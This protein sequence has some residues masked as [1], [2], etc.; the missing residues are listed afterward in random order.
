MVQELLRKH[1]G[2]A[3]VLRG[4]AAGIGL[5]AGGGIGLSLGKGA[6]LQVLLVILMGALGGFSAWFMVPWAAGAFLR[7]K[8]KFYRAAALAVIWLLLGII[9]GE[10]VLVLWFIGA[11]ALAGVLFIWSGRRTALGRQT[12][13]QVLGLKRYLHRPNKEQLRQ[14]AEENPNYF[15][16]MIPYA[17]ALG[18]DK[19]FAA[20]FGSRKL[21]KCP[22][23]S[24]V[25][26]ERPAA[27]W[28]ELLQEVAASMDQRALGLPKEKFL[29]M[30]RNITRR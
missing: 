1:T 29:G 4:L 15:F 8:H 28:L 13:A 17:M 3:L 14:Q 18:E 27:V 23:L 24:G 20:S 25:E 2:N 30:V 10:G 7:P 9:A 12:T 6:V 26:G 11:M 19:A 21:E 22:Y 5:C 16:D